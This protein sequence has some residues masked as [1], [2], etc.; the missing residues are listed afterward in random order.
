MKVFRVSKRKLSAHIERLGFS[1]NDLSQV[2]TIH[3]KPTRRTIETIQ[4]GRVP[5]RWQ[6]PVADLVGIPASGL[7][8]KDGKIAP[9][10]LATVQ[11][12]DLSKLYI[13]HNLKRATIFA[14]VRS[15]NGGGI[16]PEN[17]D[18]LAKFLNTRPIDLVSCKTVKWMSKFLEGGPATPP[19]V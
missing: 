8:Q 12:A 5:A 9:D 6:K 10:H 18:A 19:D 15:K 3:Y 13:L 11:N 4:H 2:I 16:D 7:F 17:L 1:Y 14:W